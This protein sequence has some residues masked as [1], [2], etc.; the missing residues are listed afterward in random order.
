MKKFNNKDLYELLQ[1]IKNDGNTRKLIRKQISFID[2]IDNI[3]ILT[4]EGIL[5]FENDKLSITEKGSLLLDELSVKY[6]ETNKDKW[7]EKETKSKLEN[8]IE[9]DFVF[10]PNQ[11]ELYF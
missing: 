10:L 4:L 5:K 9:I 3:K 1:I 11:N 8:K 6:K 2:I 7:I